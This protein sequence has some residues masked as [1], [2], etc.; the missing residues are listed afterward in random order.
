MAHFGGSS[1]KRHK[2]LSNTKWVE[3]FNRGKLNLKKF[4]E[5]NPEALQTTER[6]RDAQGILRWKGT[7][8]LKKTQILS[9]TLNKN[10]LKG[11]AACID[12]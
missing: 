12:Q 8:S 4:R 10:M 9:R 1:P 2:A 5:D 7:S 11:K 3:K 6:Y